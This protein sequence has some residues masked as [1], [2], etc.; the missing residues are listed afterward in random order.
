[1]L[2]LSLVTLCDD[3]EPLILWHLENPVGMYHFSVCYI[4]DHVSTLSICVN[5]IEPSLPVPFGKTVG[6]GCVIY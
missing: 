6:G 3:P 5:C 4:D 2:F 1:M